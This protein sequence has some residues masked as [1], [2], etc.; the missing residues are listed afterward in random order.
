MVRT[1]SL[2]KNKVPR[3]TLTLVFA[4]LYSSLLTKANA[5]VDFKGIST[6]PNLASSFGDASLPRDSGFNQPLDLLND[7]YPSIEVR[8]ENHSNIRRRSDESESD[9]RLVVEPGLAYRTNIGRHA[10][11]ASYA[12]RFDYHSDFS[13]EDSS[14]HDFNAKL[15]LDIS[16]RWDVDVFGGVGTAREERG[17]SGTR[18]VFF[19]DPINDDGRDRVDYDRYG[20]DLVYGRKLERLKAVLG[21]DTQTSSFVTDDGD[22]VLAGDRDRKSNSVHFDV[23]YR[24]GARTSAFARVEYTSIDFDS[25]GSSLDSDQL[26]WLVGLRVDATSRL[27]GVI[28]YGASDRDFDDSSI[29][30]FDGNSYYVNLT[31]ALKPFSVFKLGAARSVEET[32]SAEANFFV[33]EVFSLSWNH[34]LTNDVSF[35]VYAKHID[36]DFDNRRRDEFFDFGASVDYA[37]RPGLTIGLYYEDIE[38]DSNF[39]NIAFEDRVFGL[40]FR[41]DL[42]SLFSSNRS[43][44]R[45][46]PASFKAS[47]R[48]QINSLR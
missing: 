34:A 17:V 45:I 43:K 8:A 20:V 9:N 3:I 14:A 40:R 35:A 33:S 29:N 28:G 11:Y 18:D 37:L 19:D 42:R 4:A 22:L 39:D 1:N 47:Q 30:G 16:K 7:F 31:Y 24:V 2:I 48:S 36:D 46:E 26:D 13:S 12:G 41:S 25:L 23:Q 44:N 15:G 6:A 21:F 38:R 27:S 5:Q 10:F 32:G